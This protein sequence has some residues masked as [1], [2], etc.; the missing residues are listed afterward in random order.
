MPRG[1]YCHYLAINFP[2]EWSGVCKQ[3]KDLGAKA[4]GLFFLEQCQQ[5]WLSGGDG[6]KRGMSAPIFSF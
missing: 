6:E 4:Q 2:V 5:E 1:T 3:K